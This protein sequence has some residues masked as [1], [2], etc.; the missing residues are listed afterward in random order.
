MKKVIVVTIV[1]LVS[2]LGWLLLSE[3][4]HGAGALAVGGSQGDKARQ[5]GAAS[6]GR[7][8]APKPVAV[9]GP[10]KTANSLAS[11]KSSHTAQK[12]LSAMDLP[13]NIRV[14][15]GLE[16]DKSYQRRCRAIQSLGK[17]L[18]TNEIAGLYVFLACNYDDHKNDLQP[19]EFESI[20]NDTLDALLRQNQLPADLGEQMLKMFNDP[21]QNAIW[22]DYCLQHFQP[23]CEIRW[24]APETVTKDPEWAQ[25]TNAYWQATEETDST[26]AGTALIGMRTV[27]GKYPALS[28]E[29]VAQRALALAMDD[30]CGEPSRITALRICG[31]MGQQAVVPQARVLAQTG[32]TLLLRCA[33]MATLGDLGEQADM[34]LLQS[35]SAAPDQRVRGIAASALK[36]LRGRLAKTDQALQ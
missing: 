1:L 29:Q 28:K 5:G 7:G 34:E 26:I 4:K 22:R 21:G 30:A 8:L 2:V 23:Y 33:A 13:E 24:K 14:I 32:Q 18:T 27:A 25:I 9:S 31:Q 10:G 11:G 6:D 35:F 3:R 15:A 36:R 19:L 12:T 16:P 20:R 17:N